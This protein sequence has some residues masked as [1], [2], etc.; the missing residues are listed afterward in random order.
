MR[1]DQ[2]IARV[3]ELGGVDASEAERSARAVLKTLADRIGPKEAGDTA[4][5][6]P[7]ELKDAMTPDVVNAGEFDAVEF[8]RRAG[9][10]LGVEPEQARDRAR[11]VFVAL[12]EAV[13]KG[14]LHDWDLLL[15]NDYVDL[16]ARPAATGK[17]P[18]GAEPGTPG[19]ASITVPAAEFI[20]RVADR[21]GL[22]ED[23]ARLASTA[24]LETFAERIAG[25]QAHQLATQ[26][27]PPAAEPLSHA[28]G[29]P[30][31]IPA[32]EFVRRVAEREGE[33]PPFA[34]EHTRAVLTTVREAVT[35]DEWRDTLSELPREYE[36]LL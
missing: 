21:A 23:R 24:V 27:P 11:A 28:R 36:A 12:R 15:S 4:A 8:L 3:S 32:D 6:L 18:R 30:Q 35:A 16:G 14:E 22:D 17:S 29:D 13:A 2:F 33:P 34:R 9:N 31:P 10:R 1:Y 26:L 5:Q 25:G 19:H 7:K 20:R